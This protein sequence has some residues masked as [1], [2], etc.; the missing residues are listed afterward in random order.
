MF[1]P[2]R[3]GFSCR[4]LGGLGENDSHMIKTYWDRSMTLSLCM[5]NP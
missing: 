4:N 1:A 5:N 2:L 3:A